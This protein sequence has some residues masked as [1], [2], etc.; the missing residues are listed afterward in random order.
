MAN[1]LCKIFSEKGQKLMKKW[2]VNFIVAKNNKTNGVKLRSM[3]QAKNK[4]QDSMKRN[5]SNISR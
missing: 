2:Q 5:S 1:F 3:T 4:P